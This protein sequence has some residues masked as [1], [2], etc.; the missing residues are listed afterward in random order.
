M[1][2]ASLRKLIRGVLDESSR[3]RRSAVRDTLQQAYGSDPE[4]APPT[5]SSGRVNTL[6]QI[7]QLGYELAGETAGGPPK[8]GFTMT[9]VQKVGINPASTFETPLALYA[10]PVEPKLVDQLLGANE[11]FAECLV[12]IRNTRSI[13]E[14][15]VQIIDSISV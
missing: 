9:S 7:A 4:G 11:G 12:C 2:Y 15:H 1:D 3:Q 8:Y 10:Y 14:P 5:L 13:L 6:A